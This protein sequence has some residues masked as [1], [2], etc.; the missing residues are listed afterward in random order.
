MVIANIKKPIMSV[1]GQAWKSYEWYGIMS[2]L[3][4]AIIITGL[5][6]ILMIAWVL[7]E[8]FINKWQNN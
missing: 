3:D 8:H 1:F 7:Y 5:V 4:Y 6:G 2:T